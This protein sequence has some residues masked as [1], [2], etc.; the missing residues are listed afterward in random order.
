[1]CIRDRQVPTFAFLSFFLIDLQAACA[2]VP[3]PIITYVASSGYFRRLTF[4][5]KNN[6]KK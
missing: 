2:A 5:S 1:M 6:N 4:S 3:A